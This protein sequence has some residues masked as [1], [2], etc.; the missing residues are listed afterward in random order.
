MRQ[1]SE[2]TRKR[3]SESAKRRCDEQWRKRQSEK[4]ATCLDKE[5][6][7]KLYESGMT[8]EEIAIELEVTQKVIWGFM[9]RNGIRARVAKKRD[10]TGNNNSSWK[11]PDAC[12]AALHRRVETQRGKPSK[13]EECGTEDLSRTY[14]WA[15]MTGKYDDPLDYKRMC[16]SCH[17]KYDEKHL[18][19][20]DYYHKKGG[21]KNV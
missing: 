6:V 4:L 20:G 10:Q 7:K 15:C 9:K 5:T 12:Y 13:C 21:E 11:G 1:V 14:D 16:R 19:F 3:M 17:W 18:N 8:Q 2:E